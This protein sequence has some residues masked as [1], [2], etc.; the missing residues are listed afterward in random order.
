LPQALAARKERSARLHPY[1]ETVSFSLQPLCNALPCGPAVG[2]AACM[3]KPGIQHAVAHLNTGIKRE[4]HV[5]YFSFG[6]SR[7]L[8]T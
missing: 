2:L 3:W 1:P 6:D 4:A 7:K 8:R 5:D